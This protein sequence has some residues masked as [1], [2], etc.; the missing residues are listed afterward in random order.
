MLL[1]SSSALAMAPFMPCSAGVRHDLGAE[2]FEQPAAF[3]PHAF[4]HGD[5][6]FVAAGGAGEGQAD[7]GVAAGRLDDDGVL[8]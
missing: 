5:D 4:G 2:G 8:G 7:A 1:S 3:E 6:E